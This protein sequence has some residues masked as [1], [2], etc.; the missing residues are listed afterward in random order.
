[1]INIVHNRLVT[2]AENRFPLFVAA[3]AKGYAC[4]CTSAA[5]GP[6]VV[7]GI[8]RILPLA[9]KSGRFLQD[10]MSRATA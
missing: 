10:R 9:V 4:R 7:G 6:A 2:T 1:M 8:W 5:A 3:L